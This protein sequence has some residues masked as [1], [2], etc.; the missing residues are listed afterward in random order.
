MSAQLGQL[1]VKVGI[2]RSPFL[3]LD[4]D[5]A[6]EARARGYLVTREDG[7]PYEHILQGGHAGNQNE[8][9]LDAVERD[10]A[11]RARFYAANRSPDVTPFYKSRHRQMV[12]R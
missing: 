7:S 12:E 5:M 8:D 2:H 9:S 10:D 11:W 4:S 6:K 3:R 1:G